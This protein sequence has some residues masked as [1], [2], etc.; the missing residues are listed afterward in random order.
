MR[1]KDQLLIDHHV[2][3]YSLDFW[4]DDM[5]TAPIVDINNVAEYLGQQDGEINQ[6]VYTSQCVVS[7]WESV[8][9]EATNP[10][11]IKNFLD[12]TNIKMRYGV[13]TR[14]FEFAQFEK[15]LATHQEKLGLKPFPSEYQMQTKW[16][17]AC[18]FFLQREGIDEKI[19]HIGAVY[20][21]L[22]SS[23]MVVDHENGQQVVMS[24]LM[25]HDLKGWFTQKDFYGLI[26]TFLYLQLNSFLFCHCKNIET[27]PTDFVHR[28]KHI[29]RQYGQFLK[30]EKVHTIFI[31]DPRTKT[32][33]TRFYSGK[34]EL[35]QRRGHFKT[36][37]KESK[38]FGKI[39]GKFWWPPVA[40]TKDVEYKICKKEL[41]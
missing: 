16:I 25:G 6:D 3:K 1:I 38:L 15:L 34:Y 36:Y 21:A 30:N 9:L 23:G 39:E 35:Q 31:R 5:V 4:Y 29:K 26:S 41:P 14:L 33:S 20:A 32:E 17:Q 8:F 13:F 27:R 24:L 12:I 18:Q 10:T 22:N 11:F 7:P 40:K 19:L 37:T 28:K 2:K